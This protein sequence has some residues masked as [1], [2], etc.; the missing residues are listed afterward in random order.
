M[1]HGARLLGRPVTGSRRPA[2]TFES[3]YSGPS[4]FCWTEG[5]PTNVV[6]SESVVARQWDVRGLVSMV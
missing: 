3:R 2:Q 5:L 1:G 6:G 4:D